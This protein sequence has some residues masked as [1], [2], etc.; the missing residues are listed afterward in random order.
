MY[1]IH[2]LQTCPA[3]LSD[4]LSHQPEEYLFIFGGFCID[5]CPEIG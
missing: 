2:W 4:Q 3:G 5:K 1:I